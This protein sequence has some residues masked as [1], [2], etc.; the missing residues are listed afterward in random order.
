M[1]Y[2]M[3]AVCYGGTST[4][5]KYFAI[6]C[7]VTLIK[8]RLHLRS[9]CFIFKMSAPRGTVLPCKDFLILPLVIQLEY[10][11]EIIL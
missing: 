10:K 5:Y 6:N 1:V 2:Y 7:R 8:L 9:Q 3:E 4:E 11:T